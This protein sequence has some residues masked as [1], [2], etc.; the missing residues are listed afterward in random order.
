MKKFS[1]LYT[2]KIYQQ[3]NDNFVKHLTFVSASDY[4]SFAVGF[5]LLTNLRVQY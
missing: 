4:K 5:L 3:L 1:N 2:E